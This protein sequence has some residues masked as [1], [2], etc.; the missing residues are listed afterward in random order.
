MTPEKMNRIVPEKDGRGRKRRH[1]F[2]L[3]LPAEGYDYQ[4]S[5]G[6][7]ADDVRRLRGSLYSSS[8]YCGIKIRT[9]YDR[10]KNVLSAWHVGKR[11]F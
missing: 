2:S 4:L 10:E 6:A 7:T 5:A 1:D 11:V 3:L 8:R 9:V